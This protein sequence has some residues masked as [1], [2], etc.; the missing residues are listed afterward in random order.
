MVKFFGGGGQDLNGAKKVF[1]LFN[2]NWLIIYLLNEPD[3]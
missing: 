3:L 1:S 2:E